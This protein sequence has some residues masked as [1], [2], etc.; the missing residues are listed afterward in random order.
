MGRN[1]CQQGLGP[2]GI[3]WPGG[4]G[5][6]RS[7]FPDEARE[8]P[9]RCIPASSGFLGPEMEVNTRS[10]GAGQPPRGPPLTPEPCFQVDKAPGQ[11]QFN[12]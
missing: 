10:Q 5:E 8:A 3:C 12:H 1:L 2:G 11:S 9:S 6:G 4:M 7:Q